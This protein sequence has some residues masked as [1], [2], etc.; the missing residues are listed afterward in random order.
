MGELLIRTHLPAGKH[1][2]PPA[3][4]RIRDFH[5]GRDPRSRNWI[6]VRTCD[7]LVALPGGA[8]TE[9]EISL[10]AEHG[11]PVIL[12]GWS[13][14]PLQ[15]LGIQTSVVVQETMS[16]VAVQQ[17]VKSHTAQPTIVGKR[18]WNKTPSWP[19]DRHWQSPPP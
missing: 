1:T 8:G 10:A 6:E 13:S 9:A 19:S 18:G 14:S 17:F 16:S 2:H 7:L 15:R 11:T 12:F 5:E 4:K 3:E